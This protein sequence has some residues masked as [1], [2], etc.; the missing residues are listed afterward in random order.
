MWIQSLEGP[1]NTQW[2]GSKIEKTELVTATLP[3]APVS[4]S[5]IM[6]VNTAGLWCVF[7]FPVDFPTFF[8]CL[9]FPMLPPA[10]LSAC[11]CIYFCLFLRRAGRLKELQAPSGQVWNSLIVTHYGRRKTIPFM[12]SKSSLVSKSKTCRIHD[13]IF[14]S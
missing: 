7:F 8:L 12:Q 9:I 10:D 13:D 2:T 4:F 6:F 11:G 1:P 3:N 14:S 5:R